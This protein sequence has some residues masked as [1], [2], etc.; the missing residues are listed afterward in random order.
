MTERV[1]RKDDEHLYQPA[2][3]SRRI[4]E[5]HKLA[6]LSGQHMTVLIDLALRRFVADN[7]SLPSSPLPDGCP[8]ENPD[9]NLRGD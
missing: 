8:S 7:T 5:L 6:E 2:I 1:S 9:L 3:H 4:R